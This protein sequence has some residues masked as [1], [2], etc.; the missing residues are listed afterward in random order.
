MHDISD[1]FSDGSLLNC[2]KELNDINQKHL[3]QDN[4]N[5]LSFLLDELIQ[6]K[7]LDKDHRNLRYKKMIDESSRFYTLNLKMQNGQYQELNIELLDKKLNDLI[8]IFGKESLWVYNFRVNYIISKIFRNMNSTIIDDLKVC[9]KFLE[10]KNLRKGLLGSGALLAYCLYYEKIGDWE[11]CE[12]LALEDFN[13]YPKQF[14]EKYLTRPISFLL[15]SSFMLGKFE[16]TEFYKNKL[17]IDVIFS[18]KGGSAFM[19]RI[20]ETLG[21]YYLQKG[22]IIDAISHQEIA[23]AHIS[24]MAPIDSEEVKAVATDLS[25]ML[26]QNNEIQSMRN[27]EERYKLKPLP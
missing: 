17:S 5:T 26:K 1:I 2:I 8:S 4:I 12:K 13:I 27:L 16:N 23:L 15:K 11:K 21:K 7:N 3:N 22:K 9:E 20:N 25:N 18:I 19:L 6:I 14:N 24:R 10:D